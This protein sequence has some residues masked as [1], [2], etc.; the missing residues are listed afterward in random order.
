LVV[1]VRL[2]VTRVREVLVTI[3]C[4]ARLRPL[5]VVEVAAV[6]TV[7]AVTA[8]LAVVVL[9]KQV[10]LVLARLRLFRATTVLAVVLSTLVVAVAA[11]VLR[12]QL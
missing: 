3:A 1:V 9:R 12:R 11:L 10:L 2:V 5:A 4:S 8:G 6:T 7:A